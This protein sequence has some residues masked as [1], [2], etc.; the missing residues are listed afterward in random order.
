MRVFLDVNVDD[1]LS[2]AK[3][4]NNNN[5]IKFKCNYVLVLA[6]ANEFTTNARKYNRVI[7]KVWT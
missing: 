7:Q 5:A 6:K 4:V 2:I 3:T 1:Y